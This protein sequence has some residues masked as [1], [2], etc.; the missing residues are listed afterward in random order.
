VKESSSTKKSGEAPNKI[1]KGAESLCTTNS[2]GDRRSPKEFDA[3]SCPFGG[4]C[5]IQFDQTE[6]EQ[7]T[8]F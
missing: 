7:E 6:L 3:E 1:G 8:E 2:E 4:K 5:M